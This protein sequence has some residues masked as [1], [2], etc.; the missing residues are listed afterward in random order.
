MA[1]DRHSSGEA[2]S[3]SKA[4]LSSPKQSISSQ[5]Y[6]AGETGSSSK[7]TLS[8][9][10]HGIPSRKDDAIAKG[11][12][13]KKDDDDIE[14]CEEGFDAAK[15]AKVPP[16]K[17]RAPPRNLPAV[18][19]EIVDNEIGYG[20]FAARDIQAEEYI[21]HE[22]PFLTAPFNQTRDLNNQNA[23]FN[24]IN[25]ISPV[26]NSLLRAAFPGPSA[27]RDNAPFPYHE[28]KPFLDVQLGKNLVGGQL[29]ASQITEDVYNAWIVQFRHELLSEQRRREIAARFFRDYAFLEQREGAKRQQTAAAH[30]YLLASLMNHRCMPAVDKVLGVAPTHDAANNPIGPNCTFRIGRGGLCQFPANNQIVVEARRDIA[31]GEELTWDYGK[32]IR[33]FNC[34]CDIC[35]SRPRNWCAV[36]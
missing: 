35:L 29:V 4:T 12:K 19:V 26:D 20:L 23:Q 10:K 25:A 3:S 18:R 6:D 21:F 27:C 5:K 2:G 13:H 24:A 31:E 16:A 28:V 11:N 14:Q 1:G 17:H 8:S 7:A 34:M 30:I 15:Q 22:R 36:Q 32:K 33:S 9:P